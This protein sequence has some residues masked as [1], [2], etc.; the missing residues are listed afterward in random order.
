MSNEERLQAQK[1]ARIDRELAAFK[2][3]F[4]STQKIVLLGTGESGK[5]TFLKQ[6]HIIHGDGFSQEQI[7]SYRTQIYENVLKGLILLI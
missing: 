2:T 5:S 3:H 4:R 7:I 1:S 6:M